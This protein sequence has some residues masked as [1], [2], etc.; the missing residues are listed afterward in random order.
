MTR[1]ADAVIRRLWT[2][3][4]GTV[5]ASL[6]LVGPG[7][8]TD[9]FLDPSRTGYFGFVPTT[10]PVLKRIDVIETATYDNAIVGPPEPE[11]L[12]PNTHEYVFGPGDVL[13]VEIYELLQ[14]G[15]TERL[16]RTIDPDGFIRLPVLGSVPAAGLSIQQLVDR[17]K[18]RLV[19][20]NIIL[21]NPI[22]NVTPEETRSYQ[23]KVFGSV[24]RGG[25]FALNRVDLK[26]TDALALA[27][28]A[29]PTTQ[30][31]RIIRSV[32]DV[33]TAPAD[34]ILDAQSRP[35]T[36]PAQPTAPAT[37]PSSSTPSPT[38]SPGQTPDIDS[39]IDQLNI[40]GG[41]RG[42]A[43]APGGAA[44]AAGGPAAAPPAGD[45]PAGNGNRSQPIDPMPSPG[46]VRDVAI[47]ASR[48]SLGRQDAL[49]PIDI[50]SLEPVRISDSPVV[51]GAHRQSVT[52]APPSDG[53]TFVF[54]Q[55]RQEW[56]RVRAGT[57]PPPGAAPGGARTGAAAAATR[58]KEP[59]R[60][61]GP[62]TRVIEIPY[63]QLINGVP[64]LDIVIR[65]G[66]MIYADAGDRGV[67]Y[68]DG[69]VNRPGVYQLPEGGRLTVSRLIAAAG[70]LNQIAIPQRCDLIR[71]VGEDREAVIRINVAAIRNR[72]EPDIYCK[73]DDHV[74]IGTNF[75]AT[76]L[77][78]IR[79]G[80]R[81]TYG[82]GFLLDRNFGN[83]VF[84]PPPVNVVG[85]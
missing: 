72:G 75:W 16:V 51:Q 65:P 5:F 40:R 66:D 85:G 57:V 58:V 69:E 29:F 63:D 19:A 38:P 10:V 64:G 34:P 45:A 28:G 47:G 17:I 50:D 9:S 83:D 82:F 31:I 71:K 68:I 74:I 52:A 84:G 18:E 49:P 62:P 61:S 67:V 22:V 12:L 26:L 14:R 27:Q 24:E 56:V 41:G 79:N 32:Q 37:T 33:R 35:S 48:V 60:Y 23:Y 30:K 1:V 15:D 42:A 77:A 73:P 11:D 21:R 59:S 76:P 46:A 20:Q 78:V 4:A 55:D 44:P 36:A 6:A 8:E 2:L 81:M 25:L 39:L 13:V 7:C 43:P 80:F 53:T 54:D 3:V 70:G